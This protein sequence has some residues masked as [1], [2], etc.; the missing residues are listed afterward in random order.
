MKNSNVLSLVLVVGIFIV[1]GCNCKAIQDE[2]EKQAKEKD[3]PATTSSPATSSNTATATK[4]SASGLSLDKYNQ[5]KN[6]MTYKQ[7]VEIIGS[8]GTETMSSGN[9]KY[10]VESYKWDGE[11]YEYLSIVL[12]GGKVTSKTQAN[13]K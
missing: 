8:E 13:L 10:K 12:S 11:G 2:M 1:L 9:G 6:G 4:K 7:V 3:R 5:I